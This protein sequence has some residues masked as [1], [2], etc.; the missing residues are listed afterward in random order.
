MITACLFPTTPEELKTLNWTDLDVILSAVIPI[1]IVPIS[2]AALIGQQLMRG[3]YRVGIIAQPDVKSAA[4]I[5]RL[6]EPRFFGA[7]PRARW[8]LWSPTPRTGQTPPHD[9]HTPAV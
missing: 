5:T 9:D 3:G 6:G 1:L 4:D 8:I 7:S 2:G